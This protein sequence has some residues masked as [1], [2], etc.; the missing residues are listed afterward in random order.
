[1]RARSRS[2]ARPPGV[3]R[4][5]PLSLSVSQA[6]GADLFDDAARWRAGARDL[7]RGEAGPHVA[8]SYWVRDVGGEYGH[9]VTVPWAPATLRPGSGGVPVSATTTTA[10]PPPSVVS[11][12]H[13]LPFFS[14]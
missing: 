8:D 10:G 3:V 2:C 5:L 6:R 9:G 7:V 12:W 11:K 1:V 13:A 4:R 14:V